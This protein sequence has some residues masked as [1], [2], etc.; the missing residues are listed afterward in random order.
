MTGEQIVNQNYKVHLNF[1]VQLK[2]SLHQGILNTRDQLS[3]KQQLVSKF[4]LDF[5]KPLLNVPG[6]G[7]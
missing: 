2:N 1:Y 6:V 3:W 7:S 5:Q 4:I